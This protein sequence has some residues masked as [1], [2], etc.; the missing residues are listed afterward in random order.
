MH[1]RTL[2]Q[3]GLQVSEIGLGFLETPNRHPRVSSVIAGAKNRQQIEEN[4]GAS[5]S[6]ALTPDESAKAL[7]VADTIGTP[8][9]SR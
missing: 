8:G 5:A 3:T 7:A 6:P 4:I 9:W 1:Y 2:G